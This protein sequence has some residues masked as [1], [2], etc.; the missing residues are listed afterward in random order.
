[1]ITMRKSSFKEQWIGSERDRKQGVAVGKWGSEQTALHFSLFLA[2]K[3]PKHLLIIHMLNQENENNEKTHWDVTSQKF[4]P[5]IWYHSSLS[6]QLWSWI[7]PYF[8][9][10]YIAFLLATIKSCVCVFAVC[11]MNILTHLWW[12]H[13]IYNNPDPDHKKLCV[14]LT[15]ASGVM[16]SPFLIL[17]LG[18]KRW[19]TGT[20]TTE[21]YQHSASRWVSLTKIS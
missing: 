4:W 19:W 15:T 8:S 16:F 12:T 14:G 6:H 10:D 3:C 13:L 11:I 20:V 9:P 7:I 1:M 18:A 2:I 5:Y 21:I 17:L